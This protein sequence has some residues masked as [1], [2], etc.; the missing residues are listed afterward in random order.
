MRD[1]T[2]ESART[3]LSSDAD[4]GPS[5]DTRVLG[6]PEPRLYEAPF[7]RVWDELLRY[8]DGRRLWRLA[9]RDEELGMISVRC[10]M[11]IVRLVDD[12]TVWVALDGNGL[13]RVNALSRARRRDFDLG[14]NR[15]R[16]ARMLRTLDRRLGPEARLSEPA[17][18]D[19]RDAPPEATP[20]A[21]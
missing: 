2:P 15:R 12:L 13:T 14:M 7:A 16:I 18:A 19:G 1:R 17:P 11:P 6:G 4:S 5:A 3:D 10:E 9:H 21:S 20:G 8:V